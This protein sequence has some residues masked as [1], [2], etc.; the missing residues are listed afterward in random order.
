MSQESSKSKPTEVDV[1]EGAEAE[2]AKG[3]EAAL[4]VAFGKDDLAQNEPE[5]DDSDSTRIILR[6][7]VEERKA[8]DQAPPPPAKEPE[9]PVRR[10]GRYELHQ[11]LARGGMGVVIRARDSKLGRDL[12]I[13]VLQDK[14]GQ[15]AEIRHRF[16]EEAQIGGQ[17]QHPGILPVYELGQ[18]A[19]KRPYFTMKLIKGSTLAEHLEK[20]SSPQQDL[21]KF[22]HMFE[23]ICQA[24]AYAHSRGVIH[25]DL[26]PQNIMVGNFGEVQVM[27]WGLAK[28][29][30]SE[31]PTRAV[32][33]TEDATIIRT[34][35]SDQDSE[36]KGSGSDTRMG[37]VI[38][39]P[40][41]MPP[42]QAHGRIHELD[43][44]CDVFGLGA[45]LC[46]ILTGDPPYA[47]SDRKQVYGQAITGNL[48]ECYDRLE[49]SGADPE[50]IALTRRC[51]A[52]RRDE[53]LRDASVV[54]DELN[55]HLDSIQTRL[56]E[57][58]LM[59]VE[60]ETKAAEERKR[61]K[62]YFALAV[63]VC[64]LLLVGG[65]TWLTRALGR[66]PRPALAVDRELR[67]DLDEALDEAARWQEQA[68]SNSD[69]QAA[70]QKARDAVERAR[71]L[72]K[73]S[74]D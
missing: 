15:E 60:A 27:D 30:A 9:K 43:E 2:E 36:L 11:V 23:Q 1:P 62:L 40:A 5:D 58:E 26:K 17:L 51:L 73:N 56:R 47:G 63:A 14:Y 21:P 37:S 29:F 46:E 12:A 53:R 34:V 55:A 39:T 64:A 61:R 54:V 44:R 22:L 65:A 16:V 28:V 35:R 6:A 57:A 41:Y 38:G 31:T 70:L 69:S 74:A 10:L 33:Q 18:L 48:K 19:D 71:E 67:Q 8:R 45:I 66:G 7:E 4:E 25:R 59:A 68:A 13:K 49:A 52:P 72:L 50:L 3:L 24:I 20:R 32:G 42:E